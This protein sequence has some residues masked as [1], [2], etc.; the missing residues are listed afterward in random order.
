MN[1]PQSPG[2]Y[3]IESDSALFLL[4]AGCFGD[5]IGYWGNLVWILMR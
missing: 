1:C 5:Y 2:I 4:F 3:S